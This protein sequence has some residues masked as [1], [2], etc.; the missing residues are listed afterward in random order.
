MKAFIY[1][2]CAYLFV[3]SIYWLNILSSPKI[4]EFLPDGINEKTFIVLLVI[5]LLLLNLELFSKKDEDGSISNY[6]TKSLSALTGILAIAKL[7]EPRLGGTQILISLPI[8]IVCMMD[9]VI[10][11]AVFNFYITYKRELERQNLKLTYHSAVFTFW[12]IT[13]ANIVAFFTTKGLLAFIPYDEIPQLYVLI[14]W[15]IIS[16]PPSVSVMRLSNIFPIAQYVRA[17]ISTRKRE[18]NAR[19]PSNSS[20]SKASRVRRIVD[21]NKEK[22]WKEIRKKG[23]SILFPESSTFT[24]GNDD[25]VSV[26]WHPG[27]SVKINIFW[28]E[29][30]WS[31]DDVNQILATLKI[32]KKEFEEEQD[33]KGYVEKA[34]LPVLNSYNARIARTL[35]EGAPLAHLSIWVEKPETSLYLL[36][37]EWDLDNAKALIK[38]YP[39]LDIDGFYANWWNPLLIACAQ[40]HVPIVRLLLQKGANPNVKNIRHWASPLI[41]SIMYWFFEIIKLLKKY[42]ADLNMPDSYWRTAIMHGA[43]CGRYEIVRYL[44]NSGGD[45]SIKDIYGLRAI[46]YA[47][48][49]KQWDLMRLLSD[50]WLNGSS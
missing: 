11:H 23:V 36:C 14:L 18:E 5:G 16:I 42:W 3:W 33:K 31:I 10:P 39:K 38:K 46:D 37:T 29:Q 40:G 24:I 8:A 12:I 48:Q 49:K 19:N 26:Q 27:E 13:L 34:L 30:F 7:I 47:K 6:L 44:V 43:E 32:S 4:K 50:N 20:R 22:V 15:A 9:I 28:E 45:V 1:T 41:F 21:H 17:D 35:K 25:I 2:I